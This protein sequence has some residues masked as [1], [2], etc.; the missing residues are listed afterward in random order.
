M[1][2]IETGHVKMKPRWYFLVGSVGLGIL[3][4]SLAVLSIYLVSL[5]TFSLRTH[6]PMGAIRYQQLVNS[7][8]WW[9][10]LAVPIS[11]IISIVMLKKYDFS[12]KR[13]FQVIAVIFIV[14]ILLAGIMVDLSGLDRFGR[15]MMRGQGMNRGRGLTR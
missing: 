7:F 1:N 10:V 8:P 3:V 14:S 4:T 15:G 9:T 5:I 11:L 2:R 6:G 12:Y 13:N